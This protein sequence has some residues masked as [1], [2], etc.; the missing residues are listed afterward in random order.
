MQALVSEPGKNWVFMKTGFV[1]PIWQLRGFWQ[2][3]SVRENGAQLWGPR[4]SNFLSHRIVKSL[5]SMMFG[6]L[7]F[8][9]TR[10]GPQ[11]PPCCPGSHQNTFITFL[12]YFKTIIFRSWFVHG[13]L[14]FHCFLWFFMKLDFKEL[15]FKNWISRNLVPELWYLNYGTWTWYLNY[16][17]WGSR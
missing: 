2:D 3:R 6:K 5:I 1:D 13:L 17:D 4:V 14:V 10:N 11:N 9:C 12:R 15:N 7:E 16:W 8:E